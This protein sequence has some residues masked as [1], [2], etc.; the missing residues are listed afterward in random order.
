MC[1]IIMD[2][3]DILICCCIVPNPYS[4]KVEQK[5]AR[6]PLVPPTMLAQLNT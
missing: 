2:M 5:F 4:V 6:C 1:N 3:I